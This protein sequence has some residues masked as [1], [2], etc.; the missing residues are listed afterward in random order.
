MRIIFL[1]SKLNF[2]SSGGS[3]GEFDLKFRTLQKFGESVRVITAFSDNNSNLGGLPY[4]VIEEHISSTRLLTILWGSYKILK[5]NEGQ[6]DVFHVD[7]HLFLYGAGLY[8]ALG[9]KTPISAFFNRELTCW[10]LSNSDLF[11]RMADNALRRAKKKIRWL[12]EKNIGMWLANHIDW[13]SFTNPVLQK[14]YETFG[15]VT[16]QKSMILGDPYDF[17]TV[18]K[19]GAVTEDSYK[20]RN[21]TPHSPLKI[22]YSGRMVPGKGYDILIEAF[23]RL[24]NKNQF[25]LILGGDGPEE[26]LIRSRV[27]EL[28]I[29]SYVEFPGWVTKERVFEYFKTADIFIQARW[30]TELTSIIVLEAMTFG[31]PCIL[32]AGGG[33]QWVAKNSALYF[34]DGDV[35]ELAEKIE[36]LGADPELRA[37]LSSNCFAR[38]KEDELN[39]EIKL[40]ELH[41]GIKKIAAT[42]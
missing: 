23:S 26:A 41:A 8:R 36:Q 20:E 14:C 35:A 10:P 37:Q 12:I 27:K 30:R 24:K 17:K 32:P 21:T 22:F 1:T 2:I 40:K 42:L 13:L 5:K 39:Y 15:L 9:G 34:K 29:E 6:A 31:L 3:I 25:K 28:G 18:L 16:A 11:I 7:G 19:E 38:L 4:D 33:L